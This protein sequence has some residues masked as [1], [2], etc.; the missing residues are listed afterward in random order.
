[1][2]LLLA[3]ASPARRRLLELA[4]IPHRVQVSGV[5]EEAITDPSPAV[6]VQ[7]L[8]QAK[9]A[10]VAER[11]GTGEMPAWGVLGC[12]SVLEFAGDIFGKPADA[13][14]A[15]AGCAAESNIKLLALRQLLEQ[16][17]HGPAPSTLGSQE[18]Q[19][20]NLMDGVL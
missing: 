17:L 1:M 16:P 20:L 11:L 3:S 14:E 10:A 6:L 8:A 18:R 9:A 4:A 12:D 7:K 2:T 19:L 15:I 5:D 13:A